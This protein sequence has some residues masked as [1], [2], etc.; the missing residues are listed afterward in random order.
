MNLVAPRLRPQLIEQRI[1][2]SGERLAALWK[3]AELV[4]PDR[5][6]GRG[7]V[8]VTDRRGRTL[9]RA[10]DARSAREL[11]LRFAD[12]AVEAVVG[13][14]A[15]GARR[16]ERRPRATYVAAQLTLFDGEEP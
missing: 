12:E 3:M 10:A 4:H 6:L 5:P 14:A 16:V 11:L 2:R 8:R 1:G 9:T 13:D 15:P 7:F